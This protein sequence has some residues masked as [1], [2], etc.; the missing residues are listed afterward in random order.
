MASVPSYLKITVYNFPVCLWL[1]LMLVHT[2]KLIRKFR[3][4]KKHSFEG[5]S[6]PHTK[7]TFWGRNDP[8]YPASH[9]MFILISLPREKHPGFALP[10]LDAVEVW[11][12]SRCSAG[13]TWLSLL[14]F[15]IVFAAAG[16]FFLKYLFALFYMYIWMLVR[17]HVSHVRDWCLQRPGDGIRP[18]G[19]WTRQRVVNHKKDVGSRPNLG[20]LQKQ[21]A[22]LTTELCLPP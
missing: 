15:D 22:L 4:K 13:V 3:G 2:G 12:S 21:H 6:S 8:N 10:A 1:L 11:A 20:P 18:P 9:Q 19:I 17:M 16:L 7:L 5:C 14:W